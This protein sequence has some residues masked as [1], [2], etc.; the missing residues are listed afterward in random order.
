MRKEKIY[1]GLIRAAFTIG[2]GLGKRRLAR[3][4][5][6]NIF[7]P[8]LPTET[9]VK[10]FDHVMYVPLRSIE[11][12]GSLLMGNYERIETEIFKKIVRKGDVVIDIGANI[13]YYTLIAA[14]LVGDSGIVITFE[15]EPY[16]F[17]LLKKNVEVNGYKNVILEQRAVS[18]KNANL[19]LFLSEDNIGDHRIYQPS[20]SR[21]S[22]EIESIRLDDYIKNAGIDKVNIIKMDIQGAEGLALQGMHEVL[23]KNKDLTIF[24]EFWPSG[25]RESGI[26]PGDF[27]NT[28][29]KYGFSIYLI[30]NEQEMLVPFNEDTLIEVIA[31]KE[32][33]NLVCFKGNLRL[34][35]L[36]PLGVREL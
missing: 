24:T 36:Q 18:N 3:R 20:E 30:G 23:T 25:L 29:I 33:A 10:I 26:E 27:Y 28:L 14:K 11:I 8:I 1:E 6:R 9:K 21:K 12:T 7:F 19:K 2:K 16:N 5:Y 35:E 15:P 31:N 34:N 13:G 4:V 22:I 17:H 32:Q